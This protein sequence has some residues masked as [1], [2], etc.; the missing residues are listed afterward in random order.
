MYKIILMIG[1][2]LLLSGCVHHVTSEPFPVEPYRTSATTH[3]ASGK[4]LIENVQPSSDDSLIYSISGNDYF[5]DLHQATE[6]AVVLLKEEISKLGASVVDIQPEKTL[7]ISITSLTITQPGWLMHAELEFRAETA[8]GN[9]VKVVG[10]ND[11]PRGVEGTLSGT[12]A[13]AVISLLDNEK[14]QSYLKQ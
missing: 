3:K 8:D 1:F 5:T 12:I 6:T 9:I 14:I 11:S 4:I 7:K 13:I 2:V 10:I